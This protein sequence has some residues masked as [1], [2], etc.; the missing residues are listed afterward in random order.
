MNTIKVVLTLIM[1]G[2]SM[3]S[4][5]SRAFGADKPKPPLWAVELLKSE[6]KRTHASIDVLCEPESVGDD[7]QLMKACDLV[8]GRE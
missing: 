4:C 3:Q 5:V 1:I 2:L 6:M 8:L 7:N